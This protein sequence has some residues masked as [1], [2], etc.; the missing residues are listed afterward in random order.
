MSGEP[1]VHAT[2]WAVFA[3]FFVL[4]TVIGFAA[5]RWKA[6]NLDHLH[7]WGLGGRRFGTLIIWFLL[8][9]DLYTAYTVIAVPALAFATGAYA[10]FALAY[11]VIANVVLFAVIPR[12]WNV[13]R[14]HDYLTS[15]DF[16]A[17]RYGSRRLALAIALTGVL[18]TMPYIALQ[19]VGMQVVFEAMGFGGMR[20]GAEIALVVSFVVLALYTYTS[21]LR[22]PAMLAFVK[23]TMIYVFVVA[24][25]VVIPA[26]LGGYGAVFDAA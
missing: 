5:A 6:A 1:V 4:I 18:A 11:S 20:E 25:I 22:A 21:G 17:G 3:V 9:G 16:V 7:E 26:K 19:L 10:F 14:R 15:A 12:L 24:A 8:G 13:C 23:D 2:A